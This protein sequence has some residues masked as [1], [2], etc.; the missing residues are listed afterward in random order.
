MHR[1][2]LPVSAS[3]LFCNGLSCPGFSKPAPP[4]PT[5]VLCRRLSHLC[6]VL[7]CANMPGH[8]AVHAGYG[9]GQKTIRRQAHGSRGQDAADRQGSQSFRTC[10]SCHHPLLDSGGIRGQPSGVSRLDITV[11]HFPLWA[12]TGCIG[13]WL[14]AIALSVWLVA[15]VFRNFDWEKPGQQRDGASSQSCNRVEDRNHE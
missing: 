10:G 6:T 12:I 8:G 2:N 11:F 5:V 1:A 9:F 4:I 13:T 7:R 15:R 14:F 3:P